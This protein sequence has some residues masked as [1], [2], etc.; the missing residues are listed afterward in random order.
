MVNNVNCVKL[1]DEI[2][3]RW[4]IFILNKFNLLWS[5]LVVFYFCG[6]FKLLFNSEVKEAAQII[7]LLQG[8]IV[9]QSFRLF[10]KVIN[11]FNPWSERL[12]GFKC[13]I[14]Y[15]N[16]AKLH[17]F[18]GTFSEIFYCKPGYHL[19]HLINSLEKYMTKPLP[20]WVKFRMSRAIWAFT[21]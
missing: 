13:P 16:D 14:L 15:E 9:N 7:F 11:V 19:I 21:C 6:F 18:I 10:F 5:Y 4:W 8:L 17:K 2:L 1:H 20:F 3:A 12:I